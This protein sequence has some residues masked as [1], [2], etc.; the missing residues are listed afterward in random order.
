MSAFTSSSS[1]E[2]TEIAR[3]E[4]KIGEG[5]D[6]NNRG[7][8]EVERM[9]DFVRGRSGG[10]CEQRK[11]RGKERRKERQNCFEGGVTA[12]F[13]KSGLRVCYLC[14]HI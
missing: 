6:E 12:R 11:G 9:K 14:I 8:E 2:C 4:K 5:L 13:G 7:S 1:L 3:R 10:I